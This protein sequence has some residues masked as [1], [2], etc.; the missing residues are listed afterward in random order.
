MPSREGLIREWLNMHELVPSA[1]PQ[2]PDLAAGGRAARAAFT[3]IELLVVIAII[4]ILASLL[5]PALSQ[6]RNRAWSA[7]CQNN[8]RQLQTCWQLYSGDNR[9]RL[10]PNNSVIS[11]TS[12]GP[13]GHMADG[14]SWCLDSN[15][16]RELNPSNI[17]NGLL[18]PYN[19]SL[20]IYHCP[21]DRSTLEDASGQKLGQFRW[22]SYNMSQS[23]NGYPEF[24]PL[25]LAN[26]PCW[27]MFSNVRYPSQLFVFIDEHPDTILD[28]QFGNPPRGTFFS[29]AWW[30]MPSDRHDQG[31]NLS[32][33]D[34]HVEHWKWRT[35]KV[36][37][38]YV[39]QV[40]SAEKPDFDRIQNAMKQFDGM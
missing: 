33:A 10:V 5:L 9:D 27:R 22:R 2:R 31:A 38:T 12:S 37:H 26:I 19:R 11:I 21:A 15:A 7:A 35:P 36:F 39:Q 25:L 30:D 14:V 29:D 40:G 16:R 8:L 34:G 1:Q 23:V 28:A 18:F 17:V 24:S 32:F 4:A 3:L 6:A 13:V 20:G